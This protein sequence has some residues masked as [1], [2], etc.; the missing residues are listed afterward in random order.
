MLSQELA[1][2]IASM[3]GCFG[4]SIVTSNGPRVKKAA[5]C[6]QA[7]AKSSRVGLR[8]KGGIEA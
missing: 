4:T 1:L 3:L 5:V 2:R 6:F 7:L 8:H